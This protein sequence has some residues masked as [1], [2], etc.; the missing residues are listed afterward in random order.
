MPSCCLSKRSPPSRP[1]PPPSSRN[2]R[3]QARGAAHFPDLAR[4][5]I[6]VAG[7]PVPPRIIVRRVQNRV[8]K[9]IRHTDAPW[10]LNVPHINKYPASPQ[11]RAVP[12]EVWG[13]QG[14]MEGH[15]GSGAAEKPQS[16]QIGSRLRACYRTQVAGGEGWRFGGLEGWRFGGL[17]GDPMQ[18]HHATVASSVA[19]QGRS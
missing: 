2:R 12:G 6:V 10:P 17:A 5:L 8:G 4:G 15:R 11:L 7:L 16:A 14:D 18:P 1:T 19:P 3:A 13:T 9:E